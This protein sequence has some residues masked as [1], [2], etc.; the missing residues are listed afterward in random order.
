MKY[1]TVIGLEVHVEL[2]THSKIFS[3]SPIAFGA[4]PNTQTSVIDLGYPG[5]LPVLNKKALEYGIRGAMALNCEIATYTKFDRKNYFYPDNPKAY[6]ISQFDQPIGEHGYIDIEVNGETKR[7]GITRVHLE[8]DAGKLNHFS[9]GYSGCDYNRQGTALIEIVSEPDLRSPEEAYAY[10]EKLRAIIQYTGISDV[11]MEEGSLRCDANISIRPL[12]QKEF[13]TKTELKNLNSFTFVQKG[14]EY[15]QAR[16]I[17]L[18]ESGQKIKQET[19]RYD[20]AQ[21]K[22]IVMR[23]KE[24]SDDYRYF[25]EPDLVDFYVSD[26]MKEEI[27]SHIPELPD[28]RQKRY[29][30]EFGL[31]VY[32]AKVLT[33]TREMADFFEAVVAQGADAKLASNWLMSDVSAYL[34]ASQKEITEI[35][36]T[37]KALAELIQMVVGGSISSKIAKEVFKDMIE[38]GKNPAD[39]VKE[40]GLVQISD[41]GMLLDL[42]HELLDA[43]QKIVD[44]YKGGNEKALGFFVGQI[45]KAT[46]G[47]ANPQLVN[48]LLKQE[49]Q[50]R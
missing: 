40:K 25:P 45:M 7:I 23:V 12:G 11:K 17:K 34:N 48:Q 15:E 13:G 32:D 10:L 20:D 30:V 21:K 43:N 8:E 4:P 22:T 49:I 46:K 31:P 38:S 2:K 47:Q 39:I 28:A 26:E 44:G 14:L 27:R 16:Q 29:T 50:K 36:M 6:Q 33:S 1:E 42:I 41:E 3:S 24:G 35:A 19:L 18:V 9:D 5:V 37:P